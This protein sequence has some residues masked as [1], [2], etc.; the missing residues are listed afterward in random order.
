[1]KLLIITHLDIDTI[2]ALQTQHDVSIVAGATAHNLGCYL[3]DCEVLI[4]RDQI[5]ISAE[6]LT[7]APH[8]KLILR[9]HS[10][11]DDVDLDALAERNIAF[12]RVPRPTARAV[13]EHTFGLML[14]LARQIRCMDHRLRLGQREP[15]NL[16]GVTLA[17]KTLGIVGAGKIGRMTGELGHLWGMNV[18]GCVQNP[19]LEKAV[20]LR[21]HGITLRPL[22]AVLCSAD[23][24]SVHVPYSEDNHH[25][26]SSAELALM[27][28]T[29]FLLSMSDGGVVD[30]FALHE[31]LVHKQL[32]GAALDAHET[33]TW[34]RLSPLAKHDN[35]ILTPH[36]GGLTVDTQR[37]LGKRVIQLIDELGC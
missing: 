15:H 10:E 23:F 6:I 18:I 5:P 33:A 28:P 31:A 32:A 26:I 12:V 27:Q 34:R 7:L 22:K 19:T 16:K 11:T 36:I 30:E 1:M 2:M 13:A 8:L 37:G 9:L 25:L 20:V 3:A 35:V 24:L 4:Y 17:G 14:G 21:E 29:A